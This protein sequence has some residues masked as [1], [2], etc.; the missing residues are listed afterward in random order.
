MNRDP[1]GI[2]KH[3]L[4]CEE[5]K[6][7]E[8]R[9]KEADYRSEANKSLAAAQAEARHAVQCDQQADKLRLAIR[10]LEAKNEAKP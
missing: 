1:I 7:R 6:A 10:A 8:R 2:L 4:Y 3:E 9:N 5:L